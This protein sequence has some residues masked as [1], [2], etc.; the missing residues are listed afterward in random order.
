MTRWSALAQLLP[1]LVAAQPASVR[2]VFSDSVGTRI[3]FVVVQ[4]DPRTRR[5][6]NDSGVIFL[7]LAAADS[8]QLSVRRIGYA[9]FDGWVTRAADGPNYEVRLSVLPQAIKAVEVRSLATNRL[10]RSGFYRRMEERQKITS[11]SFYFTPEELEVR[12]DDRV[13]SLL[14]ATSFIRV[15]RANISGRS[16]GYETMNVLMGR[17]RCMANILLD[18]SVPVG[19][20]EDYMAELEYRQSTAAIARPSASPMPSTNLTPVDR[21]VSPGVI[22]GIEVYASASGAPPELRTKVER[23]NCPL[24]AIWTGRRQ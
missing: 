24:I 4:V 9:P 22:A 13:S 2:V 19:L 11:R 3:P 12:N 21:L 6:A 8:I 5:A 20:V 1:V 18:G 14:Q 16:A 23:A 17:G 10:Y 7:E 15:D